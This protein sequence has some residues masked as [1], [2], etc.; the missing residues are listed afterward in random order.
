MDLSKDFISAIQAIIQSIIRI[1]P[2]LSWY[3]NYAIYP[4]PISTS[5]LY[6]FINKSQYIPLHN[7][8][9]AYSYEFPEVLQI[10]S[11]ITLPITTAS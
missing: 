11:S 3:E 2:S 8:T 1:R 9:P 10:Y 4:Q 5:S 6:V 7:K